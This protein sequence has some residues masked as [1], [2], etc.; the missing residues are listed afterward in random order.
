MDLVQ[1]IQALIKSNQ[2]SISASGISISGDYAF[3][4]IVVSTANGAK[5]ETFKPVTKPSTV[6]T[7][8]VTIGR[9]FST[10]SDVLFATRSSKQLEEYLDGEIFQ[11][12][13]S[14]DRIA[15]GWLFGKA[16]FTKIEEKLKAIG[17]SF[18][19]VSYDEYK[20]K[21]APGPAPELLETTVIP[22]AEKPSAKK[23]VEKPTTTAAKSTETKPTLA[24]KPTEPKPDATEEK[25]NP[26]KH[27]NFG[28]I[29]K[30]TNILFEQD[31]GFILE[32]QNGRYVIVGMFNVDKTEKIAITKKAL[33]TIKE[34]E[35]PFDA[36]CVETDEPDE[37]V[38]DDE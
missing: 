38:V 22:P 26:E 29:A 24:A 1:Q 33:A 14:I 31:T 7:A 20:K 6:D 15:P 30:R 11:Y 12:K 4:N 34:R 21:M 18:N 37:D 36:R 25:K 35:L 16:H 19:V 9:N 28:K 13:P 17:A 3:V 8:M 23:A 10:T 5:A 27:K 32:V 2:S